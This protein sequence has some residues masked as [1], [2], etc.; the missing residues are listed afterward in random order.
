LLLLDKILF[1]CSSSLFEWAFFAG[2]YLKSYYKGMDSVFPVSDSV[3]RLA[4]SG[5]YPNASYTADSTTLFPGATTKSSANGWI[6]SS[7]H[8]QSVVVWNNNS[9]PE[10][11][12]L[13]FKNTWSDSRHPTTSY[14]STA[15]SMSAFSTTDIRHANNQILSTQRSQDIENNKVSMDQSHQW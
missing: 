1:F 2:D 10:A 15:P 8:R 7:H 5:S 11:A 3:S 14:P 6:A 9:R 4:G 13:A 12:G